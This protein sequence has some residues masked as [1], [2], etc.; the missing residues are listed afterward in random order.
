MKSIKKL[1]SVNLCLVFILIFGS[2]ANAKTPQVQGVNQSKTVIKSYE[3]YI[4]SVVNDYKINTLKIDYIYLDNDDIPECVISSGSMTYLLKYDNGKINEIY[5]E[6]YIQEFGYLEKSGK[7]YMA[8]YPG[9]ELSYMC[10]EYNKAKELVCNEQL[11]I[12]NVM[13]GEEF[14]NPTFSV[15]T[16][17][18]WEEIEVTSLTQKEFKEVFNKKFNDY[19]KIKTTMYD[20]YIKELESPLDIVSKF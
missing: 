10:F 11:V 20:D 19:V 14:T 7:F 3:K 6:I 12:G 8:F 15:L 18:D 2:T 16:G 1:I 9:N 13:C 4:K 5:S 17:D